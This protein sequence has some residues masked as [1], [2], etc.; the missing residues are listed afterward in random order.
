MNAKDVLTASMDLS[1]YILKTYLADLSDADLMTRPTAGCNHLAWQLGHLIQSEKGLL[2]MVCPGAGANLP[3][4][5]QEQH[6]K[7]TT[8]CDDATKFLSK[9]KYLELYDAQR[10]ATKAALA[11][12]S[13]TDLDKP[14]P[15]DFKMCPTV[16]S[17]FNLIASHGTMHSGQ[18]ATARRVLGKPIVI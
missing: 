4:G 5:F 8:G 16:G 7:E 15:P 13:D 2:E 9:A 11:K 17:V 10:A 3:A 12:L 14:G 1:D 18:F 6:S